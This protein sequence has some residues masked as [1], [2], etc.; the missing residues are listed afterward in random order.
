MEK[1]S[2]LVMK[3]VQ[4]WENPFFIWQI[5]PSDLLKICKLNPRELD[6]T[7]KDLNVWLLWT[8]EELLWQEN[9]NVENIDDSWE[10][11]QREISL[12]RLKNIWEYI[13]ID[14]HSMFPNNI[15]VWF[16]DKIVNLK[17]LNSQFNDIQWNVIPKI[18]EFFLLEIPLNK[19]SAFIIDWQHRLFWF[20][21]WLI[22]EKRKNLAKLNKC[23]ISDVKM[24]E[25]D[26]T[27]EDI[28]DAHKRHKFF[29][30]WISCFIWLT[31]VIEA[32]VFKTINST[33]QK[34][35]T[36]LYIDLTQLNEYEISFE[37]IWNDIIW[38]M[39]SIEESP[40]FWRIDMLWNAKNPLISISQNRFYTELRKL[41]DSKISD[42]LILK[43]IKGKK[44][45]QELYPYN[46]ALREKYDWVNQKYNKT[47]K[48]WIPNIYEKSHKYL[49]YS[50]EQL[51]QIEDIKD[52]LI[53]F[54]IRYFSV[55]KEVY[56][57]QW[58]NVTDS[59]LTKSIWFAVF[60]R[61]ATRK[62]YEKY[63]WLSDEHNIINFKLD[64]EKIRKNYDFKS[65]SYNQYSSWTG[66]D[67]LA[68][69]ILT[70]FNN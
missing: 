57:D 29:N 47:D 33:P 55:I 38:I 48:V 64:V 23:N 24:S 70:L 54:L 45:I 9:S 15:I 50:P 11:T 16:D 63:D 56:N 1:I 3:I 21:W 27:N 31:K 49:F 66:H 18:E 25:I 12:W 62:F 60:M 37:K 52:K 68:N 8:A 2:L 13:N 39:N 26:I 58:D 22:E 59:V 5:N 7:I 67:K 10:W 36:S 30:V 17:K 34:I 43:N 46:P 42:F 69:N 32:N 65:E 41:L 4:D 28:D 20:L 61:L 35:D 6:D 53:I 44:E 14:I 51:N 19:K 40:W